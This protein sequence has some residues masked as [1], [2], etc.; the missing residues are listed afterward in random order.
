MK[1]IPTWLKVLVPILLLVVILVAAVARLLSE[2]VPAHAQPAV[3]ETRFAEQLTFMR[4]LAV[5]LP[6]KA[7]EDDLLGFAD[8]SS[9]LDLEEDSDSRD[10]LS[11]RR[12]ELLALTETLEQWGRQVEAGQDLL[13][14]PVILAAEVLQFCD[15]AQSTFGVK[16]YE[17]PDSTWSAAMFLPGDKQPEVS[18]WFAGMQRQVRYDVKIGES[19]EDPLVIRLIL[20][21]EG[22]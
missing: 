5:N 15:G 19:V 8:L 6:I 4:E 9:D 16:S 2:E 12:E 20:D 3:L 14:D 13:A 18:L 21:L 10:E 22:L 7:C 17:G 1:K 11:T